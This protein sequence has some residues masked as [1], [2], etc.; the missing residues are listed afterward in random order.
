MTALAVAG[1]HWDDGIKIC[2]NFNKRSVSKTDE[3]RSD[4]TLQG[5]A[6]QLGYV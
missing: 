2:F 4:P 3:S 1:E 6:P 5:I